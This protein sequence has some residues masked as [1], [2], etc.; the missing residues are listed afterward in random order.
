[1]VKKK[2]KRRRRRR[3]NINPACF[4]NSRTHM[5]PNKKKDGEPPV[6]LLC[7]WLGPSPRQYVQA[8]HPGTWA[9]AY[10]LVTCPAIPPWKTRIGSCSSCFTHPRQSSTIQ[11]SVRAPLFPP[12]H[13]RR[14]QRQQQKRPPDFLDAMQEHNNRP[15]RT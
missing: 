6:S 12:R 13:P 10:L 11:R 1:M 15:G 8:R 2:E 14:P 7:S 4:S 9:S 5:I 3:R